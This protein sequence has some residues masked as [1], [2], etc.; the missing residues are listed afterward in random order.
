LEQGGHLK[1]FSFDKGKIS[2]LMSYIQP[3]H[4]LAKITISFSYA[5]QFAQIE[6]SSCHGHI[7][8]TRLFGQSLHRRIANESG[9]VIEL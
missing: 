8:G 3:P 4:F 9:R 7:R 2:D 1:G 5:G 6:A